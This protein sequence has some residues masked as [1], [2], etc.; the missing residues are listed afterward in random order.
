MLDKLREDGKLGA[1]FKLKED[2]ELIFLGDYV[3]RGPDSWAILNILSR[4]KLNNM[5]NVHLIRGNHEE[6]GQINQE[7]A[8]FGIWLPIRRYDNE[9]EAFFNRL[10]N[11]V[12]L[13]VEYNGKTEYDIYTHGAMPLKF[14]PKTLHEKSDGFYPI[15]RMLEK[16]YTFSHLTPNKLGEND[17][18]IKMTE[19][20][21]KVRQAVLKCSRKY[22]ENAE[23]AEFYAWEWG[24][25]K[26]DEKSSGPEREFSITI[27]DLKNWMNY[28]EEEIENVK[29]RRFFKGHSH[30]QD[31]V[32]KGD[33]EF[34]LLD[35]DLY[36]G[37]EF[38]MQSHKMGGEAMSHV[39][40]RTMGEDFSDPRPGVLP[41]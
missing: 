10:P 22:M 15:P 27:E 24:D 38:V 17:S 4:L 35:T 9:I 30:V 28:V 21:E 7:G 33:H 11:A 29:I 34:Y 18:P 1:D 39:Y 16:E 36:K 12:F 31:Q 41:S 6:V 14:N 19:T 40:A 8:S 32:R 26:V 2:V 3:D 25:V 23:P 20:A 37:K 13:G 5:D